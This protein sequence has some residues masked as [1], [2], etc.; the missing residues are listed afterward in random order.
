MLK[1]GEVD[2]IW[3]RRG[4]NKGDKVWYVKWMLS[5]VEICDRID[6]RKEVDKTGDVITVF[7]SEKIGRVE[8]DT[9]WNVKLDIIACL[10]RQ[11]LVEIDTF[12]NVKS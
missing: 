1:A 3:E 6:I 5:Q 9:F 4:F 2:N 7:K 12:W 10:I 11:D 8:I